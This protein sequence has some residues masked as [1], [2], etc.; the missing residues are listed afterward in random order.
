MNRMIS[1]SI[2]CAKHIISKVKEN[3][4]LRSSLCRGISKIKTAFP[5][6]YNPNKF[7]VGN[8]V[9]YWFVEKVNEHLYEKEVL[10]QVRLCD[11]NA[12]RNDFECIFDG[13]TIPFSLKYS[14][15]NKQGILSNIRMINKH[16]S[17]EKKE[18]IFDED[19]FV[20]V[21]S[22]NVP[23]DLTDYVLH[24][25]TK[26]WHGRNTRPGKRILEDFTEQDVCDAVKKKYS[27]KIAFIPKTSVSHN[28]LRQNTDGIDL[29]SSFI[30]EFLNDEK[31]N[32]F[33]ALVDIGHCHDTDELDIVRI[34]IENLMKCKLSFCHS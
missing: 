7:L 18:Y 15:P 17:S 22:V 27:G 2:D 31:N 16:T 5:T 1:I 33:I 6:K 19:V 20:I 14:T 25:S 13:H 11:K 28:D 21:P 3:E 23:R 8:A 24:P 30:N 34:G 32:D 12:T 9:E 4:K 10:S 26:R 29:K